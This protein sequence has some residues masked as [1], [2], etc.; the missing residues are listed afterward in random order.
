MRISDWSS[1]VC[2]SDLLI[3]AADHVEGGFGQVIIVA[4]DHRLERADRVFDRDELAGDAGEH[5]GDVERLRKKA[6]N[7][8][9]ARNR[10]LILFRQFVHAENGDDVLQALV[11]LQDRLDG[12][13]GDRKSTRLNSSPQCASRM[14]SSA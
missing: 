2:S 1:D 12:T 7:L 10:Q 11:L 13:R 4:V 9:R 6:L 5:L 14:P 3:D 8:A